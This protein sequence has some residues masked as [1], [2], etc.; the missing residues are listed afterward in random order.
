MKTLVTLGAWLE[1]RDHV[2][3]QNGSLSLQPHPSV[4]LT[5]YS[6]LLKLGENYVFVPGK[7][8]LQANLEVWV[9]YTKARFT[10]KLLKKNN[11]L[12]I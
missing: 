4:C 8:L 10:A 11:L 2:T 9:E 1:V 3:C 7:D 6:G 5:D 12:Y